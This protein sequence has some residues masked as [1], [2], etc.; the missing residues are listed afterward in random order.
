MTTMT[1]Y[2]PS[3]EKYNNRWDTEPEI[4]DNDFL[5]EEKISMT[6][7]NFEFNY[8]YINDAIFDKI[9]ALY[10]LTLKLKE[11]LASKGIKPLFE[12]ASVMIGLLHCKHVN[13]PIHISV[14][15][16]KQCS[17]VMLLSFLESLTSIAGVLF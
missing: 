8:L 3:W 12:C 4:W 7:G 17:D 2:V 11:L 6:T 15:Q 10:N 13:V 14:F 5:D 16:T 1:K 9:K